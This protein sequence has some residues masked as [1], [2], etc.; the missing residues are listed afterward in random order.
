MMTLASGMSNAVS[1]TLL[2]P[3]HGTSEE[4]LKAVRIFR[5][6]SSLVPPNRY[7]ISL[8]FFRASQYRI[9]AGTSSLK[10]M[11]LSPR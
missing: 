6:S 5:L 3:M 4:V 7:G 8:T 1:P 11:I 10:M 2:S 9:S